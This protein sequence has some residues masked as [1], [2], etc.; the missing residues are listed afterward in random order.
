MYDWDSQA[1]SVSSST[2][3]APASSHVRPGVQMPPAS[4]HAVSVC[5]RRFVQVPASASYS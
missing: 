1:S 3:E 2:M 5:A 4:S